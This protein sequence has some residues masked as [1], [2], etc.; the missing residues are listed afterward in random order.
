MQLNLWIYLN[1]LE[2]CSRAENTVNSGNVCIGNLCSL[3]TLF[4]H[5]FGWASKKLCVFFCL[6]YWSVASH[7]KENNS[8]GINYAGHRNSFTH[9]PDSYQ[10]SVYSACCLGAP[11]CTHL[12]FFFSSWMLPDCPCPS[13][14]PPPS[15]GRCLVGRAATSAME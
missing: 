6:T 14:L 2:V 7:K 10:S 5:F 4:Q 15:S 13:C 8:S 3:S 11:L 9:T 12:L 1:T